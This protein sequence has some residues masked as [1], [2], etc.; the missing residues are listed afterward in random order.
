MFGFLNISKPDGWTS[1]DVVNRVQ[2]LV[3]PAKA[4]H[5]GTLDPLATGVLPVAVGP[6]TRLVEYLQQH[7]KRYEA[8]FLLGR[9]SPSD[10]IETEITQLADSTQPAIS[11]LESL[12]PRFIG[13]IQQTPPS[14]SAVKVAGRRAYALAR[15]GE[16]V[17]LVAR[18][19]EIYELAIEHYR[20]PELRL[21]IECGSGTY[22]RS[23]GRDLAQAAGTA[24][25]MS[26]LVR[27]VVGP[28]HSE[29]AI[30]VEGLTLEGVK[31][32]LQPPSLAVSHLPRLSISEAQLRELESGRPLRFSQPVEEGEYAAL[33]EGGQLVAILRRTTPQ[34]LRVVRNF[35]PLLRSLP[36]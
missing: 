28:F 10:D 25:V 29:N 3:R 8:T 36:S 12:L 15:R 30:P 18:P 20:Y 21:N 11:D 4:G 7:H 27:T 14:F 34:E 32:H 22:V 5:A 17:N 24:A 1:R 16:S 23:L 33:T 2:R 35:A 31:Q 6:A 19:V 26:A 13:R 9:T